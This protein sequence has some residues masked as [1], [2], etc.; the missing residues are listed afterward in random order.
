[1]LYIHVCSQEFMNNYD[2]YPENQRDFWE[3][4]LKICEKYYGSRDNDDLRIKRNC[5]T[6]WKVSRIYVFNP[7][8][9]S[10]HKATWIWSDQFQRSQRNTLNVIRYKNP[11]RNLSYVHSK[12]TSPTWCRPVSSMAMAI[13]KPPTSKRFVFDIYLAATAPE[14]IRPREG[15][16][17]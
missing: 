5:I 15:N 7:Y 11:I 1:M 14:D 12:K 13:M 4:I 6:L 9:K 17:M 2:L 10:E 8:H 16:K 3:A